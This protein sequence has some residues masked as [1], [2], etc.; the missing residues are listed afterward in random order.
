MAWRKD[1]RGVDQGEVDKIKELVLAV[2]GVGVKSAS[3]YVGS[4]GMQIN[5]A[6]NT[7]KTLAIEKPSVFFGSVDVSEFYTP[8]KVG[9]AG[10]YLMELYSE[11]NGVGLPYT[12]QRGLYR[13]TQNLPV[14][15]QF[16][17]QSCPWIHQGVLFNQLTLHGIVAE[18]GLYI[19]GVSLDGWICTLD[20]VK[21]SPVVNPDYRVRYISQL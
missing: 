20:S 6:G 11:L 17:G 10:Q 1:F 16:I 12:L 14:G 19:Y 21:L 8:D 7:S 13:N 9:T 5:A 4:M 2:T 18:L 3:R 15:G